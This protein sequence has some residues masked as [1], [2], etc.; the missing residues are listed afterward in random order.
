MEG[1]QAMAP[2]MLGKKLGMTRVYDEA[3]RIVPV[4]VIE[5][6][7]CVVTQAIPHRIPYARG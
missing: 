5:L 3:G 4:T 7:P 6:G 1:Q 2:T